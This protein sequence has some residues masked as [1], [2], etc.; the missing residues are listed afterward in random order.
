MPVQVGSLR[1]RPLLKRG[2]QGGRVLGHADF[3][4]AEIGSGVGSLFPDLV[5]ES[6]PAR[7]LMSLGLF[8]LAPRAFILD[9]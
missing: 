4:G 5:R 3:P 2:A 6:M 8:P 9:V 1:D 7:L